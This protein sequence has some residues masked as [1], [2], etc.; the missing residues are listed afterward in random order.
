VDHPS[1]VVGE[2]DAAQMEAEFRRARAPIFEPFTLFRMR[3][4]R[5]RYVN[6][7][8]Q[9][10]RLGGGST[11]WPPDSRALSI[12]VF[13]G[14][15]A[16]GYHV[17]DEETIAS[18]MAA[19]LHELTAAPPAA[20]YNFA[21]AGD[22][23]VQER[24]RLEN[25]LVEGIK[26][27][28]AIFIDGFDEFVAPYYAP[29]VLQPLFR[30]IAESY[31]STSALQPVRQAMRQ[32][33]QKALRRL[34]GSIDAD[35]SRLCRV[36]GPAVVVSRYLKNMRMSEAICAAFG[37]RPLFVWQ[38]V[39]CYRYARIYEGPYADIRRGSAPLLD[40]VRRGYELMG[41]LRGALA[42]ETFLWLA[43]MQVGR[44]EELYA[45]ADHYTVGFSQEI[46]YRIAQHLLDHD[47]AG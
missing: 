29:L 26:P 15:T 44:D 13:G 24:I 43:D 42:P 36:P 1:T 41:N 12:F 19:R 10:F 4:L 38:P 14:S 39:P 6:V 30:A 18:Q 7:A 9:G 32:L 2:Q 37:V 35:E 5:G 17:A 27:N 16:F 23:A 20:A 11:V 40:A 46:G 22:I 25:L 47:L 8:R 33:G 45:D 21:T 34:A 31:A 28:V 3:P